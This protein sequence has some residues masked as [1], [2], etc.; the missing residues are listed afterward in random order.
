MFVG[1]VGYLFVMLSDADTL[2]EMGGADVARNSPVLV[3]QMMAGQ[4]FWLI[5][6]W[7]WVFAQVV[8]RDRK[9]NLLELVL[10]SPVSLRGL[11]FARYAGAVALA[12]VLGTSSAIGF[13]L[14]PALAAL[15]VFPPEA[16]GPTPHLAILWGWVLFVPPSAIG[17]GALYVSAALRTKSAAGPFAVSSVVILVWMIAM[18]VLRGGD[19]N[20]DI[21]TLIDV[22]GFG[23][24][25][26]QT[27]LWTP[28]EKATHLLTLTGPLLLNRLV[29]MLVPLGLLGVVTSRLGREA[30]VT[31][32]PVHRISNNGAVASRSAVRIPWVPTESTRPSWVVATLSEAAW[33]LGERCVGGRSG[34]QRCL[35][36]S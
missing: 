17:L 22:S 12:I 7:A 18:I 11:L 8:T 10:C 26:L 1:L 23:E 15:H 36:P 3:F 14:V 16:V 19:M 24:A 9:A 30:L 13:W 35:Q 32:R 25:E 5:F 33:N 28:A 21:A 29:W 2:R 31:E 20:E 6:I 34:S 27:K 4:S